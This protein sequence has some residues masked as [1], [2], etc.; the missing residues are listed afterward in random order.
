VNQM[1][2]C[3]PYRNYNITSELNTLPAA[4]MPGTECHRVRQ[5]PCWKSGVSQ[6]FSRMYS[7][8]WAM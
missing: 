8:T 7:F 4:A 3:S 6:I 1:A 5:C 2:C